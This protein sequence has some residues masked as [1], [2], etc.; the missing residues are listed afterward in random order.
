[1]SFKKVMNVLSTP[2][3]NSNYDIKLNI[4]PKSGKRLL[5]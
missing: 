2:I 4:Y 5:D 3:A 1:M